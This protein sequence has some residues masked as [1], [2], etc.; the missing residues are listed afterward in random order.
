MQGLA[1]SVAMEPPGLL[2]VLLEICLDPFPVARAAAAKCTPSAAAS[3]VALLVILGSGVLICKIPRLESRSILLG[4]LLSHRQSR[5]HTAVS[6]TQTSL[7][8]SR[9]DLVVK[10]TSAASWWVLSRANRYGRNQIKRLQT[11]QATEILKTCRLHC[12]SSLGTLST[13]SSSPKMLKDQTALP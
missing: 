11:M 13:G 10:G 3:L 2:Q 6:A 1:A 8:G 7:T 12:A 5:S 9:A 4:I